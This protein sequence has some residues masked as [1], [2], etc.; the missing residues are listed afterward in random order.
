MPERTLWAEPAKGEGMATPTATITRT[1]FR[2]SIRVCPPRWRAGLVIARARGME[3]ARR[4]SR[5]LH[6]GPAQ[7]GAA[8]TV[9]Y[10]VTNHITADLSP[11]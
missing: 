3:R 10:L 5:Q 8:S 9:D 11:V 6:R 1:T 4:P 2:E 7:E